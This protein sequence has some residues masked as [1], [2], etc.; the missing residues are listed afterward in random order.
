M[1]HGRSR[2]RAP[3]A[4]CD[5][6]GGIRARRPGPRR[7]GR[8]AGHR[9][10]RITSEPAPATCQAAPCA[11]P[12][13]DH[14][15]ARV[16]VDQ[17]CCHRGPPPIGPPCTGRWLRDLPPYNTRAE[18]GAPCAPALCVTVRGGCRIARPT[19]FC[20]EQVVVLWMLSGSCV[21]PI[22]WDASGNLT[23]LLER[24]QAVLD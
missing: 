20:L 6:R 3:R 17:R 1:G 15:E 19:R 24:D 10:T 11:A 9:F 18:G 7:A 16:F 13:W 14:C 2:R 21:D 5:S 23:R 22:L 12:W 8:P 4:L